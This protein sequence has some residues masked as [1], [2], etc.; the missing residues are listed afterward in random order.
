MGKLCL[1]RSPFQSRGTMA[2]KGRAKE[3]RPE[4]AGVLHVALGLDTSCVPMGLRGAEVLGF[5]SFRGAHGIL[6]PHPGQADTLEGDVVLQITD[7]AVDDIAQS[8]ALVS[9]VSVPEEP[10]LPSPERE[11]YINENIVG[12]YEQLASQYC[13]LGAKQGGKKQE[14]QNTNINEPP[15]GS[16]L[17][18]LSPIL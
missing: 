3:A 7:Q 12:Y 13:Q 1:G 16:A 2:T 4:V 8:V 11:T 9:L 6:R 17:I 5:F 10:L 14:G 18:S 15:R